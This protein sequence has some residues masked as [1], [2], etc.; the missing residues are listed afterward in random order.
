MGEEGRKKGGG[1]REKGRER[2]EREGAA[3]VFLSLKG[4]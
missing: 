1:W 4:Q 3:V 2:G